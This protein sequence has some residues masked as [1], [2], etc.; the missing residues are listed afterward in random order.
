MSDQNHSYIKIIF[1]LFL[2]T[3]VGCT[4]V[5]VTDCDVDIELFCQE[6]E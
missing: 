5:T 6:D 2:L 1:I 3:L 4:Y